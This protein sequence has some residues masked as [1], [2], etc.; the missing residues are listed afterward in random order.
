MLC[1]GAQ[2]GMKRTEHF[3]PLLLWRF[4]G[5]LVTYRAQSFYY[6]PLLN[7]AAQA[8]PYADVRAR[9]APR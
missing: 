7:K 9:W 4:A 8:A 6:A 5:A 1:S 3:V 2:A